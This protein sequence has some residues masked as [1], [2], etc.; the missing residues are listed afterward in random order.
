MVVPVYHLTTKVETLTCKVLAK[1]IRW[2]HGNIRL[3]VNTS[4]GQMRVSRTPLDGNFDPMYTF[5]YLTVGE[6]YVFTV[7]GT[8]TQF[9]DTYPTIINVEK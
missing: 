5:N 7:R 1:S 4:C 2:T 9:L 8:W 6:T 3:D